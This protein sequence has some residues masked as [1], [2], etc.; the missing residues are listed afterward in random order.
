MG[1]AQQNR[2]NKIAR[3]GLLSHGCQDRENRADRTGLP[4]QYW[5]VTTGLPAQGCQHRTARITTARQD[6]KERA[7]RKETT[8]RKETIARK[9]RTAQKERTARKERTSRKERTTRKEMT[10]RTLL[11]EWVSQDGTAR[12]RQPEQD[13]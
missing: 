6:R 4:L 12:T 1:Q 11:L 9:E 3:A 2:Q 13:S 7:A 8:A 5:A 10:A